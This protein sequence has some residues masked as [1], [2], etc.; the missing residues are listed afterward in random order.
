MTTPARL[1]PDLSPKA[2]YSRVEHHRPTAID[3]FSGGGGLSVGLRA[4]RFK[5]LGAIEIEPVAAKTYRYNHP[6]VHLWQQDIVDLPVTVVRKRLGLA[7]GELDLL[8]GCPPCQGFSSMRTLNGSRRVVDRS[9][10]LLFQF[11]RFVRGL[12]PKLLMMENVPGLA[13]NRRL[14]EFVRRLRELHYHCD[15]RIVDV[16][17]Y[18]V[19]QRRR[20]LIFLASRIGTPPF[21]RA[22]RR[23]RTVADAIGHVP[24]PGRSGDPL[25]DLPENRAPHVIDLIR[26]IPRNGGSRRDAPK[27]FLLPCHRRLDGF[28]DV[29]GRMAWNECA[30]TITGGCHNPSKG[31][32]LHPTQN[33]TITLRE[34][35]LL[36]SFPAQY[37]FALDRGKEHTAQIIGNA[38]PPAF[39]RRVATP[40]RALLERRAQEHRS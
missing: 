3:L 15:W 34:A 25:H 22:S 11:L 10:D 21:C 24:R 32:F 23:K 20:R 27:R 18:G 37:F 30:P 8:A 16:S 5:V 39:I 28:Y 38:L 26:H 31:R 12:R 9:N 19:P 35:A 40:L 7:V 33:R 13:A 1:S 29:Y 14:T 36:Q 17:D 4:A 6:S 2:G